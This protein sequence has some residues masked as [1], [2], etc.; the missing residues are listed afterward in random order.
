MRQFSINVHLRAR[1]YGRQPEDLVY[2]TS[3]Q[4]YRRISKPQQIFAIVANSGEIIPHMS[5][6]VFPPLEYFGHVLGGTASIRPCCK[7][8]G[9]A[10]R[11]RLQMND[12]QEAFSCPLE[13]AFSERGSF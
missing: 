9:T 3:R 6:E 5:V 10:R 8:A 12:E 7:V 13:E 4:V 2:E 11:S 1:A